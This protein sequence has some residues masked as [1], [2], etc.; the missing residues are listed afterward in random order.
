MAIKVKTKIDFKNVKSKLK[1]YQSESIK[2]INDEIG[3]L[4]LK[5]IEGGRSPVKGTVRFQKYSDSYRDAIKAGRYRSFSKSRSPVNL[6]LTGKLLKSLQVTMKSNKIEI[7]F[8]DDLF[9]IHNSKGAG[10]SKV[11]RRMLPTN[12]GELFNKSITLRIREILSDVKRKI[13]G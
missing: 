12:N 6:K 2:A 9:E 5:D 8:T 4:I 3:K 7:T 11:I 13:F 10:K 1:K